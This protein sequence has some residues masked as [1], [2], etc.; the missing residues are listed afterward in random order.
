MDPAPV[1]TK[2]SHDELVLQQALAYL[3]EG[4]TV[5]ARVEGLFQLPDVIYGY[6]PDIVAESAGHYVIVEIKKGDV[7]WPKISALD[8]FAR[9]H[10][11][12]EFRVIQPY[13]AA[14]HHQQK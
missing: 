1:V 5:R 7:D 14:E 11:D 9:E 6:R 2:L 10:P 12:W 4:Y 8:R 13:V 3:A